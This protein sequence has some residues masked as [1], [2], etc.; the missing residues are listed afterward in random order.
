MEI[1]RIQQKKRQKKALLEE[2][3]RNLFDY[4]LLKT[5]SDY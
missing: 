1:Y 3:D 4:N 5:F 2:D